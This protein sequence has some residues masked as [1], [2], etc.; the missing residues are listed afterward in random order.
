MGNEPTWELT[1]ESGFQ[2]TQLSMKGEEEGEILGIITLGLL[3]G[4]AVWCHEL[5]WGWQHGELTW[6][7]D[8]PKWNGSFNSATMQFPSFLRMLKWMGLGGTLTD[9]FTLS[10]PLAEDL[11]A[12]KLHPNSALDFPHLIFV[13]VSSTSTSLCTTLVSNGSF[14][15][16]PSTFYTPPSSAFKRLTCFLSSSLHFFYK[17]YHPSDMLEIS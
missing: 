6:D 5:R 12:N 3:A 16:F 9:E 14:I 8:A 13:S 15:F 11:L 10:L 7:H 4:V 2:Q 17:L 1:I